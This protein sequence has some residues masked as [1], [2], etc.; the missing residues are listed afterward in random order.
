[1]LADSEGRVRCQ[2][3]TLA[4]TLLTG[5]RFLMQCMTWLLPKYIAR[6]LGMSTLFA[7]FLAIN[8]VLIAAFIW[9]LPVDEN[10]GHLRWI[11][12]GASIQVV[13]MGLPLPGLPTDMT[14]IIF[15]I[16]ISSVGEAL[17]W[18]RVE[19]Y[20]M[21]MGRDYE[22]P[23]LRSAMALPGALLTFCG[24]VASGMLLDNYCPSE[25]SCSPWLWAWVF[26]ISMTTPLGLGVVGLLCHKLPR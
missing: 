24:V 2:N 14:A 13:A 7:L 16:V 6:R 12:I 26:G 9:L 25:A 1:M 23:H 21:S 10:R 22:I 5:G 17:A 15:M 4:W 20:L 18:P 19:A 11:I 8:P 3:Y